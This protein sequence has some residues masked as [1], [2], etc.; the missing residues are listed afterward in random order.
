MIMSSEEIVKLLRRCMFSDTL[1][2]MAADKIEELENKIS[3]LS[4]VNE[5]IDLITRQQAE[6]ERLQSMNQAKLETIHDLQTEIENLKIELSSMRTA[7]NSYKMHY[8]DGKSE[9]VKE[10]AERLKE[11]YSIADV[12]VTV[13]ATDIDNLV[14]EMV[15]DKE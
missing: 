3:E 8:E 15:G 10:F 4:L 6:I 1:L 13:D 12:I 2:K 11:K 14:K 7:A 5:T 9:A